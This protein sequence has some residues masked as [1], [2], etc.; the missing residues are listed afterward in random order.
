MTVSSRWAFGAFFFL[1][2]AYIGLMSPYAS[3]Y[4]AELGFGAIEIAALMSMLQVTRIL[5]PFSWGWLSDYLSNRV[6]IMRFCAV[7]ACITFVAIFY[8]QEYIPLLIWMFVLHTILSSMVPLGEAATVHTLY[9]DESF[10]HRYGRIRLW[11]SIGFITMVL[12]AGE[13]FQWQ[14]IV[15]FPWLGVAVLILLVINTFFLREPKIERQPLVRGELRSVLRRP[16]VRW[17]L[18]SAFAMIFGHAALYVFYSLYL[19]DLGYNK[20]EIGLFWTLGV[21]AEVVFFYLQSKVMA[22]FSPTAILQV[23]FLFGVIRFVLIGYFASTSLLILA[24][25]MHAASFAAHHSASTRLIQT[26]FAGPMQARGQALFTT[27]AYGFGGTLGGLCAGWIWDQLGPNQVFGMAAL[28]CALGWLAI[29][30]VQ[31]SPSKT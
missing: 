14:G 5:G 21:F 23:T 8:L 20:F 4:F 7:L 12:I 18:L 1:Y 19:A 17:F 3:L 26:W 25:L 10:Y 13:I 24:Q 31:S 11:G 9:K 15:I 28:A 2:F 30:Q 27:I 16:E 6:G 29:Y 22:R